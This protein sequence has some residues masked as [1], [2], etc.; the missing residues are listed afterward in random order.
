MTFQLENIFKH[1]EKHTSCIIFVYHT[2]VNENARLICDTKKGLI[3]S[4]EEKF[5]RVMPRSKGNSSTKPYIISSRLEA[6]KK[7]S[8]LI[9]MSRVLQQEVQQSALKSNLS[10]I[11]SH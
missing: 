3:I 1:N 8:H 5:T 4:M 7:Q 6:L 11:R 9:Q 2:Q 10:V